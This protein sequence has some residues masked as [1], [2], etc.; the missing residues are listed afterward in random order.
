MT[1][2]LRRPVMVIRNSKYNFKTAPRRNSLGPQVHVV[3]ASE[4]NCPQSRLL[5]PLTEYLDREF[6]Q[7]ISPSVIPALEVIKESWSP[8]N[9]G[10]KH[11]FP[12]MDVNKPFLYA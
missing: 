10:E 11:W 2:K 12:S 5:S 1:L 7:R 8:V 4:N 3:L 6:L 9:R